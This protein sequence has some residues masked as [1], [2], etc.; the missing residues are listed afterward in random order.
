[1]R[2]SNVNIIIEDEVKSAEYYNMY[3]SRDFYRG[4]S[5]KMAG[6]W[7]ENTHYF[8]DEHIIDF[9]SYEGALLYCLRG[10]VSSS[11]NE[12]QLV[13]DKDVIVGIEPNQFWEFIMGNSGLGEK[14]E[15]GDPGPMGPKGDPGITPQLKIENGHWIL[16]MDDGGTWTD[17]G[18]ATGDPGQNGVNGKDGVDGIGVVPGGTTGQALV[19]KS[20]TDYDTEWKTISGGG[21]GDIPNLSAEVVSAQEASSA[22]ADVVLENDTFKF[23]FALPRGAAGAPG[24]DGTNGQDGSNGSDG[25]D[26]ISIRIMYTKTSN[27]TPPIV[28]KGNVNPGSIWG[29]SVP[30]HSNSEFIW[31]ITASFRDTDLVGE[32]SDPIQMTGEPGK[33]GTVPD[34]K[35]YIYKLSNSKPSAP[36]G[37]NPNPEG[38]EDY[39]N[40]TGNWWQ[41]IGTVTGSTGLVSVWSEVIPVNGRDGE[42]QDGKFTEMR[43]AVSTSNITA[44]SINKSLRTPSGWSIDPP[45]KAPEQFMWMTVATINPNDTLYTEWSTPTC[46][47]GEQGP[48]GTPGLDGLQGERGEQGIPGTP[49]SDGRTSYFHIKYSNVPNP[50]TVSQITETPSTYIGTYVDYTQADSTNPADYTWARFEGLQGEQGIPGT[51]GE[52]GRTSYLHIKY[53]NDGGQT[54]T[55]NNGEDVGDWIGIYTDYDIN[56]SNNPADYKWTKIKGERGPQGPA[57]AEGPAGSNGVSGIPGVSIEIKYSIGTETTYTGTSTLGSVRNPSGWENTVP[58]VTEE[59]PYIWFIQS[60]INYSNNDDKVGTVDGTWSTPTIL[61]GIN[62][63]DGAPGQPGAPG[64]KGQIIYP[65]GIYDVKKVYVCDENKA[66]YVYDSG[67]ANYWVLNKVGSWQGTLHSDQ[68][69]STD[70]SGSWVKL[71]AFEAV[72]AKLGIIANGLIGSAVFNDDYMFSQQGLA[73]DGS[74]STNYESFDPSIPTGGVFTPNI[75]FNFKTGE[76]HLAAGKILFT[77]RGNISADSLKLYGNSSY[78]YST[79]ETVGDTGE[80]NTLNAELNGHSQYSWASFSL[81]LRGD[82][83]TYELDNYYNGTIINNLRNKEVVISPYSESKFVCPVEDS[84]SGGGDPENPSFAGVSVQQFSEIRLGPGGIVEYIFHPTSY[85][86]NQYIGDILIKNASSFTFVDNGTKYLISKSAEKSTINSGIVAKGYITLT[87]SLSLKSYEITSQVPGID[88]IVRTY[89][90]G[91]GMFI[92]ENKSNS[93]YSSALLGNCRV[94]V[95]NGVSNDNNYNTSVIATGARPHLLFFNSFVICA[96]AIGTVYNEVE[97][98]FY[99]MHMKPFSY[100]SS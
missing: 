22:A 69:P 79:A 28:I 63:L 71:E 35:I 99:L 47:S 7:T 81:M 84:S 2:K 70:T 15:K 8:N 21:G 57:G 55:G 67:D 98:P 43:F 82:E 27:T 96:K 3:S 54:F 53:S 56:D 58:E 23:S 11:S 66:P 29:N 40:T 90:E 76:G 92:L 97:I 34:Y 48:Q 17:I 12:P 41:C 44:P 73:S 95:S 13:Y 51:N 33:A 91:I 26:G 49:G 61:S 18:Q 10:H 88:L 42:A 6:K 72:Y 45:V 16:S 87:T 60:R 65:E 64:S 19:K 5:F 89:G 50:T 85:S 77:K 31:S 59:N 83:N 68:T 38:W 25:Q 4:T 52:D 94:F 93:D 30:I 100:Y 20:S 62:G 74:V 78:V 24:K 36:T 75:L 39:P 1:M 46:I 86:N 14:G 80:I 32:W 9:I 37:T